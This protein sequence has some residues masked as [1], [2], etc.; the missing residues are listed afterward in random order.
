MRNR[1]A[2]KGKTCSFSRQHYLFHND[3]LNDSVQQRAT[4]FPSYAP[5]ETLVMRSSGPIENPNKSW[6]EKKTDA[7]ITPPTG[8]LKGRERLIIARVYPP[9]WEGGQLA[10]AAIRAPAKNVWAGTHTCPVPRVQRACPSLTKLTHSPC[11]C[12]CVKQSPALP[13]THFD[14]TQSES[15]AAS[16]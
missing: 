7:S 13:C 4:W 11:L 9:K 2:R 16:R 14:V 6:H 15:G 5:G 8:T 10:E 3:D 12:C 1:N